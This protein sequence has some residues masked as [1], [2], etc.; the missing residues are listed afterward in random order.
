MGLFGGFFKKR[1][2]SVAL[3]EI[4]SDSVAGGYARYEEGKQAS[5]LYA[6][7]IPIGTR[8]NEPEAPAMLR[9]LAMLGDALMH[10]GGPILVR[11]AGSGSV[12]RVLVSINA[13]WQR[14]AVRTEHFEQKIP[15]TFTRAMMSAAL[16]RSSEAAPGEVLSDES[17]IGCI[18]N[19]YETRDPYGKQA[20]RASVVILTSFI[21][22]EIAKT[23]EDS[24]RTLYHH[25]EVTFIAGPS[26][27]YQA[28]R[29]AFPHER[30]AL[31]IDAAGSFASVAL[32][33]KDLLVEVLESKTHSNNIE[34]W[35]KEIS[36]EFSR[37][38]EKFPLPR[39]I[40]LLTHEPN[41]AALRE[42]LSAADLE[43]LWLSDNPPNIISVLPNHLNGFVRPAAT[44]LS[45]LTLSLMA[46]Y[47]AD[48]KARSA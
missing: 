26:L 11:A 48:R 35:L 28:I 24:L 25:G 4:G 14:F 9:A 16:E 38:A 42:A 19:G 33:R 36:A 34:V 41:M 39:T 32:V 6:R 20:Q 31:I 15:F 7:R 17:V 47:Y 30:D 10:D 13:P 44:A 40:F 22:A 27:R 21:D 1:A 5:L 45:D 2:E 23:I 3:I 18:L 46:L 37:L 12:D 29:L 8:R 43:K